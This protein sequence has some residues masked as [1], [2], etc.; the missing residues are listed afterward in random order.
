MNSGIVATPCSVDPR[1]RGEVPGPPPG[2]RGQALQALLHA[3]WSTYSNSAC[4]MNQESGPDS[5]PLRF[6]MR[7]TV[8]ISL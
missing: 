6:M 5:Y 3:G 4:S 7:L 8:P 1:A 2:A